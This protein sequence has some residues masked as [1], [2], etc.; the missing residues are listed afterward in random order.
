MVVVVCEAPGENFSLY[1]LIYT[2]DD[3]ISRANE[4][5]ERGKK[6]FFFLYKSQEYNIKRAMYN[7]ISVIFNGFIIVN[8][9]FILLTPHA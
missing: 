2:S 6:T 3:V 1:I 7:K 4:N 8:Y 9:L 5:H